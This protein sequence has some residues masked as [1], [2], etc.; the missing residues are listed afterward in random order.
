HPPY[1]SVFSLLLEESLDRGAAHA[2]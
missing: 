1:F 2:S